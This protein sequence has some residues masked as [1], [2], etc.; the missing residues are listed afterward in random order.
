MMTQRYNP[1]T[2]E[3]KGGLHME[4][5]T[6]LGMCIDALETVSLRLGKLSNM[7]DSLCFG[8]QCENMEQQS[9]DCVE[10]ISYCVNDIKNIAAG[11]L[12]QLKEFQSQMEEKE[13]A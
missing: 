6:E 2:L 5:K 9:V 11:R 13:R 10:C 7:I 1:Q 8:M 3:K 4:I 12:Q